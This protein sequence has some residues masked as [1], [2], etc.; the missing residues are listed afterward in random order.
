MP[1]SILIVDDSPLERRRLERILQ[2]Y[3]DYR[4]TFA[5]SGEEALRLLTTQPQDLIISDMRMRRINGLE[6]VQRVKQL[7]T[8]VPVILMT[9][10]GNEEIAV[11]AL[12]AGAASYVPKEHLESELARTIESIVSISKNRRRVISAL[13]FAETQFIIG[14]DPSLISPL[15]NYFQEQMAGMQLLNDLSLTRVG[16]ALQIAVSNA[17]DH[18]NLE[19]DTALRQFNPE[20]YR[21][22]ADER[23]QMPKF[24]NR[25]VQV[26]ARMTPL[27][28]SFLITDEGPGFDTSALLK[29]TKLNLGQ[30]SGRGI[31]LMRTFMDEVTYNTRGNQINLVKFV[32]GSAVERA[33]NE[34]DGK[35]L[36]YSPPARLTIEDRSL[37][38]TPSSSVTPE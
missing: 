24:A 30:M 21:A 23:R 34:A 7:T 22:Q 20:A 4:L 2:F 17:I 6:L 16:V 12:L 38:E 1:T 32:S 13:A 3:P 14:N 11:E 27:E 28:V 9:S 36:A 25:R 8:H 5:Q 19:L 29:S 31:L 10:F 37:T 35:R 15:I 26:R 33:M 18:G